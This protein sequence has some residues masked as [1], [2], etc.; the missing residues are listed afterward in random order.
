MLTTSHA[1]GVTTI[2]LDDGKANAMSLEMLTAIGG[3]LDEAEQAGEVVLLVGREGK[4]S[5]GY[6]LGT[7]LKGVEPLYGMLRAGAELSYRMVNF[8]TPIV[9]ACTGHAIA[10]GG[11]LLLSSDYRVGA[12]GPFKLGANEVRIN[13]A[14]PHWTIE[15]FRDRVPATFRT[16]MLLTGEL[17]GPTTAVQAGYLDE[18]VAVDQVIDRARTVAVE[19]ASTVS[20]AKHKDTKDLLRAD[21]LARMRSAIDTEITLDNIQAVVDAATAD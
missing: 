15:L 7:F 19:L 20:M 6:D 16:R 1:D 12:E 14:V 10:M 17:F 9:A 21:L 13:M 18:V 3:A 11:F 8:P 2:T 4:F 5:A